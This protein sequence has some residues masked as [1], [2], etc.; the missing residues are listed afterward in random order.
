MTVSSHCSLGK[1][2][3][4][5]LS[6]LQWGVTWGPSS[7]L[8]TTGGRGHHPVQVCCPA[9][10]SQ[11]AALAR[12][13]PRLPPG[14]AGL[15]RLPAS[16]GPGSPHLT[17]GVTSAALSETTY[18]ETDFTIG[19]C[20]PSAAITSDIVQ[21]TQPLGRRAFACCFCRWARPGSQPLPG[22]PAELP[23]HMRA[24]RQRTARLSYPKVA[25]S[26]LSSAL[27]CDACS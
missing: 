3:P 19:S 2:C 9:T 22:S 8:A 13:C 18:N 4:W 1:R 15:L 23:G 6:S 24:A 5:A 7:A 20:G 10:P 14:Q 25:R 16:F 11:T 12:R 27:M 17:S 21:D 26:H